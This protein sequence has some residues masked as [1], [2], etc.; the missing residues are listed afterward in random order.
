MTAVDVVNGLLGEALFAEATVRRP[1]R[2]SVWVAT[3]TGPIPGKQVWRT[4]GLTDRLQA[5]AVARRWE[6]EARQQRAAFGHLHKKP[7][8]RVRR[9]RD[10]GTA[11][12]LAQAEVARRLGMSIRGVR[13]VERRAFQKLRNHP[14]LKG[15]WQRYQAG[16]LDEHDLGPA[17]VAVALLQT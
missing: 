6:V 2:S 11:G 8:V 7:T 14:L 5:L 3:F 9:S 13:E 1:P 10:S 17:A 16:E 4:T 12:G 15:I